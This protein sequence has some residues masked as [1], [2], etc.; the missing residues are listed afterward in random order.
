MLTRALGELSG[1]IGLPAITALKNEYIDN[2]L[3][4]ML[5]IIG[6]FTTLISP[7]FL[8]K[9]SFQLIKTKINLTC[10]D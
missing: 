6:L 2:S 1:H 10:L 7:F 5:V 9:R 4:S 3:F 8:L